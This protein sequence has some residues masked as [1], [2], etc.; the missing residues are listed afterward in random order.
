MADR[1]QIAIGD[2]I[3][4]GSGIRAVVAWV[5]DRGAPLGDCV[6]VYL[7]QAQKARYDNVQWTGTQWALCGSRP[8]VMTPTRFLPCPSSGSF[9]V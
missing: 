6:A 4:V 5:R 2:L 9:G 7:G 3:M 8:Q 1:P